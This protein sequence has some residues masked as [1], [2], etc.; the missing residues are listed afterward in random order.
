MSASVNHLVGTTV[1]DRILE[2]VAHSPGCHTRYVAR[3]LPD[4]SLREVFNT[5]R[6][7]TGNGQLNLKINGQEGISITVSPW[8]LTSARSTLIPCPP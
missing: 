8:S 2:I 6:Y 3:L 5:V 7:L 4:L 1:S